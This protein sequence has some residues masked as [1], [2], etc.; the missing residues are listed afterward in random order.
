VVPRCPT[1]GQKSSRFV[2]PNGAMR[3]AEHQAACQQLPCEDVLRG[4]MVIDQSN[5]LHSG[6][7][8]SCNV[9]TAL[10]G[11]KMARPDYEKREQHRRV[12]KHHEKDR[13]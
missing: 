12:N 9:T 7:I 13:S 10:E 6:E 11:E 8:Y 4:R 3:L 5:I 2:A 1:L